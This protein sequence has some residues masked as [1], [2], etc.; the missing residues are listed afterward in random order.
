MFKKSITLGATAGVLAGI[1][2]I[3]YQKVYASS[4]GEGFSS[5]VKPFGILAISILAGTCC[6][7]C[8]L[9]SYKSLEKQRGSGI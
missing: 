6:G 7:H 8:L 3:I 9:F 1:A 5:I 2:S 4:L